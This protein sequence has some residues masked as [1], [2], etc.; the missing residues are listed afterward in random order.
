[1]RR[2]LKQALKNA[3]RL[4]R[5]IPR[6]IQPS[7]TDHDMVRLAD[8]IYELEKQLADRPIAFYDPRPQ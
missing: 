2:T 4:R 8:R 6:L 7:N 5:E 3:E 1:M